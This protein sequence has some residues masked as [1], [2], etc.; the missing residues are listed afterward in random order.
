MSSTAIPDSAAGRFADALVGVLPWWNSIWHDHGVAYGSD[1]PQAFFRTIAAM[2]AARIGAGSIDA[3][4]RAP[5]GLPVR[6]TID[7]LDIALHSARVGGDADL[8]TLIAGSFVAQLPGPATIGIDVAP[9]LGPMLRT[10]LARRR[11]AGPPGTPAVALIPG[12]AAVN[13]ALVRILDDHLAEW[14]ELLPTG[15]FADLVRACVRWIDSGDPVDRAAVQTVLADIDAV[16]GNDYE[17]DEI[18]ATGFV[19]N[20]PYPDEDGAEILGLLGPRL[21]A[22]YQTE[23]PDAALPTRGRD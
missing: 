15:Y 2:T 9:S 22:E 16:Y 20:L 5:D 13:P 18:I 1:A 14:G 23:R 11:A 7:F 12:L 3:N 17:A 8:V 21:R 6:A 19:E 4:G 10:E